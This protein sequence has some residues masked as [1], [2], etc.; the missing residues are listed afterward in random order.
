MRVQSRE[1]SGS[2]A[3]QIIGRI[4]RV[5]PARDVV[6]EIVEEWID[7]MQKMCA[8]MGDE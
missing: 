3:G 2:P 4:D 7:A 8:S 1:L 5:R 6:Y